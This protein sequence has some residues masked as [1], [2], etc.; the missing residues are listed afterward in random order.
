[1]NRDQNTQPHEVV[2]YLTN[3]RDNLNEED[4]KITCQILD[5]RDHTPRPQ[6]SEAVRENEAVK[7]SEAVPASD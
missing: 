3:N 4:K 1:M 7:E 5:E 6:Y 2:D